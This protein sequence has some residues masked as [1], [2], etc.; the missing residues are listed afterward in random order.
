MAVQ[1]R[2]QGLFTVERE[3]CICGNQ[4]H[5]ASCSAVGTGGGADKSPSRLPP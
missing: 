3:L 1:M 4:T 5:A 2:G